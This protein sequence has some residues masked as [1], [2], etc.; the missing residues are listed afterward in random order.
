MELG[1]DVVLQAGALAGLVSAVV[2]NPADVPCHSFEFQRLPT[3][4]KV[5]DRTVGRVL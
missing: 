1:R 2:S 3:S 5:S 4:E